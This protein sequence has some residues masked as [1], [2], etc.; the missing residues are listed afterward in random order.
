MDG[1]SLAAANLLEALS[2]AAG[3]LAELRHPFVRSAPFSYLMPPA[4]ARV[5][6]LF[7]L[8]DGRE[9][10]FQVSI[11]A[12]GGGFEVE[13][14]VTAEADEL[15]TLPRETFAEIED[16]LALLDDYAGEVAQAA[17]RLIDQVLNT[18]V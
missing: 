8:P 1:E 10:A 5:G 15:M 17:G 6:T 12:T 4:G 11:A 14:G 16:A 18:I 9:V 3:I 2:R 7:I 13:G